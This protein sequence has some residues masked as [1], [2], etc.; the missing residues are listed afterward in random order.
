MHRAATAITILTLACTGAALA[1]GDAAH[2]QSAECET[3]LDALTG[4]PGTDEV[5]ARLARWAQQRVNDAET[6]SRAMTSLTE[7]STDRESARHTVH[8]IAMAQQVVR[9]NEALATARAHGC[10]WANTD[11]SRLTWFGV[12]RPR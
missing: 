10:A 12:G 2:R 8:A 9:D 6:L 5:D 1:H 4:A 11:S 7:S 3:D